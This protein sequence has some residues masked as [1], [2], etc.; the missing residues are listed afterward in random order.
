VAR[1]FKRPRLVR[2]STAKRAARKVKL[3]SE[4]ERAAST[5]HETYAAYVKAGH[6]Q[7]D[8]ARHF[9]VSRQVVGQAVH[10]VAYLAS[11]RDLY[12]ENTVGAQ[13][14]RIYTCHGCGGNG[15]AQDSPACPK[16]IAP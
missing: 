12:A 1:N 10:R 4:P 14:I 8:T 15:H 9:G 5:I 13:S 11:K 7:A 2:A 16:R 6:T 3:E